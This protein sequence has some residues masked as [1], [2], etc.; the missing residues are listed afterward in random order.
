MRIRIIILMIFVL[1]YINPDELGNKILL[2]YQSSIGQTEVENPANWHISAKLKEIGFSIEFVDA[3]KSLPK[4]TDDVYAVIGWLSSNTRNNPLELLEWYNNI[5]DKNIRLIL[6]GA[7]GCWQ[8]AKTLKYLDDFQ[9]NSLFLRLGVSYRGYW[10][11]Q[12]SILNVLYTDNEI[13]KKG[14]VLPETIDYFIFKPINDTVKSHLII[15]RKDIQFSDSTL[16]FTSEK[17]GY[18]FTN[19]YILKNSDFI[20]ELKNFL[21]SALFL[22]NNEQKVVISA[23]DRFYEN[24]LLNDF[25]FTKIATTGVPFQKLLFAPVLCLSRYNLIVLSNI[26][27][28]KADNGFI[29]KIN[30]YVKDGGGL[31]LLNCDFDKR[32]FGLLGIQALEKEKTEINAKIDFNNLY[33]DIDKILYLA[34]KDKEEKVYIPS[35]KLTNDCTVVINATQKDQLDKTIP[36]SW[37]KPLNK[38]NVSAWI[39]DMSNQKTFISIMIQLAF[40]TMRCYVHFFANLSI[41]FL[42][43]FPLPTYNIVRDSNP[44]PGRQN[45]DDRDFISNYALPS[46]LN[47]LKRYNIPLSAYAI[48]S[49]DSDIEPPFNNEEMLFGN[50]NAYK[51][52]LKTLIDNDVEI[53]LHGYNHESLSFSSTVTKK[54]KSIDDMIKALII[55]KNNF[56]YFLGDYFEPFSYVAPMNIIDQSGIKALKSVFPSIKVVST[57]FRPDEES[58]ET[59]MDFGIIDGTDIL[60]IPRTS[61]GFHFNETFFAELHKSIWSYGVW[62][63][64]LHLDDS[65]D[66]KR[67]KGENWLDLI[68]GLENIINYVK[69]TY[70]FLRFYTARDA[71]YVLL[72][73]EQSKFNFY[74]DQNKKRIQIKIPNSSSNPKFFIIN[75]PSNSKFK[76][77]V[78]GKIEY[79]F[80]DSKKILIRTEKSNT[81]IYYE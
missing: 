75:L 28:K 70:P 79:T 29:E 13:Y 43:D 36:I 61:S 66:T 38:G 27:L 16:V 71:Y 15:S 72:D 10:T 80:S 35:Y 69:K 5:L 37:T 23:S 65:Y 8:D 78:N 59:D 25:K 24:R 81:T 34:V 4:V 52:M 64:F 68:R 33:P 60:S 53:G 9:V 45:L 49:Y 20:L 47:L 44:I 46:L 41:F 50:D 51:K 57:L 12:S 31:L 1:S 54:W 76:E 58:Y 73:Y 3:D 14:F 32:Y 19:Q 7:I 2:L 18:V 77:I 26:D 30:N 6:L 74:I 55:A 67:S 48:F 42:D 62:P 21:I 22:T 17:G 40:K 56:K 63:H 39:S 11:N